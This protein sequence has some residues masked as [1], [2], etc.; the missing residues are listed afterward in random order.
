MN[1]N[2]TPLLLTT[3]A[4]I[5]SLGVAI[6]I[7]GLTAP[8]SH[9]QIYSSIVVAESKLD[10]GTVL[11]STHLRAAG[12]PKGEAPAGD[13]MRVES[14]IGRIVKEQIPVGSPI[15]ESHLLPLNQQNAFKYKLPAGYRAIAVPVGREICIQ[16]LLQPGDKVDVVVTMKNEQRLPFSK[17]LIQNVEVLSAPDRKLEEELRRHPSQ[18]GDSVTLAVLPS[19]A[20]KLSLA[21]NAGTV[22]LLL[23]SYQDTAT[24]QTPGVT[25]DTLLPGEGRAYRAV[26][27]IQGNQRHVERFGEHVEW[28]NDT[29]QMP[30]P[31]QGEKQT[32]E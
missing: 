26:E 24:T 15:L 3:V 30:P 32:E 25:Q 11:A 9:A 23:R 4:I 7:Y 1:S 5:S 21:L 28:K 31:A 16:S 19:D 2:R 10:P 29:P 27:V 8:R 14:V 12:Y 20:E 22:Q 6:G 17:L 18:E 13:F